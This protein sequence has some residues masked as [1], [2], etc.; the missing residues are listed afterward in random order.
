MILN[1]RDP[2]TRRFAEGED[3][4][5]FRSFAQQEAQRLEI[6]DSAETRNDLRCLASNHFEALQGDRR[7][8]FSIRI[9]MKWRLCFEWSEGA[10]GPSNVEI[11]DY[12]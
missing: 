9:N 3:V 10:A 7:G 4:K 1:Y 8:Q 11:V 12:H 2:R 6:L 5:E